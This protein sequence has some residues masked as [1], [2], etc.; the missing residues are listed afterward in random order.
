MSKRKA[1][2]ISLGQEYVD[3]KERVQFLKDNCDAVE[4]LGYMKRFSPEAITSMK[5]QLASTS[6]EINDI[7]VEKKE[8]ITAYKEQLKPLMD[9]KKS[10][11]KNIK[12]KAEFVTEICY[13]F[14]DQEAMLTGYY[15]ADGDLVSSRPLAPEEMQKTIFQI[16]KTGTN[17]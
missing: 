6:I 5:N 17:D 16:Q 8:A 13:K 7:E 12:Q 1:L 15:N 10:L 4:D 9:G 14:V 3:S 11:L 2:D